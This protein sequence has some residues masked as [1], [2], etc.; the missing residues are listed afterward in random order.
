MIADKIIELRKR[1]GLTQERLAELANINLRTLQRIEKSESIPRGHTLQELARALEVPI[2]ELTENGH[3]TESSYKKDPSFMKVLTLSALAFWVF[4]FGNILA[5]YVLWL[6]KRDTID[7]VYEGGKRLI[8]Y[9]IIWS[10]IM[11]GLVIIA[12]LCFV[13]MPWYGERLYF[14]TI[15]VVLLLA[16]ANSVMILVQ[17][18]RGYRPHVATA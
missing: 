11:Y 9:Q 13:L 8:R 5:P 17:T 14:G 12:V 10:S 6:L 1:K 16:I 7:G 18:F 2:D 4:P 3:L 15:A